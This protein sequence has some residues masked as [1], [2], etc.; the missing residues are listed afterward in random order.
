MAPRLRPRGAPPDRQSR[1]RE[2]R[3]SRARLAELE[4]RITEK[5]EAVKQIEREMASPGFYDDRTRAEAA[6]ERHKALAWEVSE[7][8][9]Q[10][11]ALQEH[12]EQQAGA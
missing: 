9:A 1:D 8:M 12:V 6:I 2:L 3:K 5:E 4:R 11:E 7:L 10:W